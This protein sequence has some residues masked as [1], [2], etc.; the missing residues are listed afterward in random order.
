MASG[1]PLLGLKAQNGP[2]RGFVAFFRIGPFEARGRQGT[3]KCG[4]RSMFREKMTIRKQKMCTS[5]T[6]HSALSPANSPHRRKKSRC[7]RDHTSTQLRL[8]LR[9]WWVPA[10]N[11]RRARVLPS[12]NGKNSKCELPC[13]RRVGPHLTPKLRADVVYSCR[14]FD[15]VGWA[16]G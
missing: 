11:R 12:K 9:G 8:A 6:L 14:F 16:N 4:H 5:H 1:C 15:S 3:F 7:A 13:S 10:L 2:K